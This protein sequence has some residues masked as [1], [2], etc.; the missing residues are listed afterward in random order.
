[1][2][3]KSEF[4]ERLNQCKI[5]R[6]DWV[7]GGKRICAN[8]LSYTEGLINKAPLDK[9]LSWSFGPYPNGTI[10]WN[11]YGHDDKLSSINIANN[12]MSAFVEIKDSNIYKTYEHEV[13][14]LQDILDT[15]NEIND[16]L[17]GNLDNGHATNGK[18]DTASNS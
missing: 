18:T 15:F 10:I 13:H 8:S 4:I 12:S 17:E 11:Y 9:L 5:L 14:S 2:R 7:S 16:I 3:D 6:D 1:M